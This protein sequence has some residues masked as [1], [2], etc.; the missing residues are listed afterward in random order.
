MS[1]NETFTVTIS[2]PSGGGGPVPSLGTSKSIT[3]TIADDDDAITGIALTVSP[4]SVGEDRRPRP[5]SRS[6]PP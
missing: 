1:P 2:S 5:N 4:T 3:T 6:P